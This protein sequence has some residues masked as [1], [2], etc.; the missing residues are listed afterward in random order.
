MIN[1]QEP[2]S[3]QGRAVLRL[4]VTAAELQRDAI[5]SGPAPGMK[6]ISASPTHW[7]SRLFRCEVT[8]FPDQY[9]QK[10]VAPIHTDQLPESFSYGDELVL[11]ASLPSRNEQAQCAQ[12]ATA[13]R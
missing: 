2:S 3:V 1:R 5:R 7:V 12:M 13:A 6:W 9:R 10:S 8:S 11:R 4:R